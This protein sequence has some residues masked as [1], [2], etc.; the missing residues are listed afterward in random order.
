MGY[1]PKT[2]ATE[3]DV[4]AFIAGSPKPA[5][6]AAL[7]AL[8]RRGRHRSGLVWVRGT[9]QSGRFSFIAQLTPKGSLSAP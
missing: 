8:M 7:C 5:D 6:G 2:K 3:A 1:E 4:D 9:H